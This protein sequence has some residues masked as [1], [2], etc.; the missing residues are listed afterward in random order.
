M[1]QTV[2]HT[3]EL[4]ETRHAMGTKKDIVIKT[5]DGNTIVDVNKT[6]FP[7]ITDVV[8]WTAILKRNTVENDTECNK[9]YSIQNS[10]WILD[11]HWG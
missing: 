5:I 11:M 9:L 10:H 8:N 7:A 6:V 4:L 3:E 1:Q 2:L